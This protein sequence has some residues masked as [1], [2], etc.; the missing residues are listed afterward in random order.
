M[1]MYVW[2]LPEGIGEIVSGN[3]TYVVY[4]KSGSLRVDR[5][6]CSLISGPGE[7]SVS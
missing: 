2:M 5:N 3:K 7:V 1:E 6:L 4:S